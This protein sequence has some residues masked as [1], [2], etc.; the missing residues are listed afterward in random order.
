M[1][2]IKTE[3]KVKFARSLSEINHEMKHVGELNYC[4]TKLAHSFLYMKGF[5]KYS[6]YNEIIGVLES[7]KLEFYRR[8]VSV[9]EDEKIKEN[10]DV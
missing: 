9:Y 7:A 10:G 5:P 3:E 4:I 2:Y 1:P 8:Q 6:D